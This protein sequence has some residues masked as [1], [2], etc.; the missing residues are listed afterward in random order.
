MP[1]PLVDPLTVLSKMPPGMAL[2]AR[3]QL[4]PGAWEI[5]WLLR[6]ESSRIRAL[7]ERV[8]VEIRAGLLREPLSG[9]AVLLVPIVVR[10]GPAREENLFE[11]WMN[12]RQPSVP[13]PLDDLRRQDRIVIQF[14]GDTMRRE[15][16][17][18]VSNSL[19]AFA[20][21]AAGELRRA[22]MWTMEAFDAAREQ[23]YQPL[24]TVMALW[25]HLAAS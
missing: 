10:I 20:Q 23:V 22:P 16:T 3:V 7:P 2:H 17:I 5:S 18:A 21:T 4:T 1:A 24:P 6:E 9:G 14:Y 8:E 11:S 15:R 12:L 25:R 13:D 19:K